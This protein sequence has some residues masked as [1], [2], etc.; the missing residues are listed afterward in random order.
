MLFPVLI[1]NSKLHAWSEA[2]TCFDKHSVGQ[3]PRTLAAHRHNRTQVT[4]G[5]RVADLAMTCVL[6][7]I[8]MLKHL[9]AVRWNGPCFCWQLHITVPDDLAQK[10]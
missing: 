10:S 7:L 2:C 1:H 6:E 4:L 5:F 8:R 9:S 3:K